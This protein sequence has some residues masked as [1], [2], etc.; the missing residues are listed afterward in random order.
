MIP[1]TLVMTLVLN[2]S[3][4]LFFNK[5]KS[6]SHSPLVLQNGTDPSGL[7]SILNSI[8]NSTTSPLSVSPPVPCPDPGQPSPPTISPAPSSNLDPTSEEL[9]GSDA[10]SLLSSGTAEVLKIYNG[11]FT[12]RKKE[13]N[14]N[15]VNRKNQTV[16]NHNTKL[17]NLRAYGQAVNHI[18]TSGNNIIN[19]G[20]KGAEE[21]L[22]K[23][24]GDLDLTG[25]FNLADLIGGEQQVDS[26]TTGSNDQTGDSSSPGEPDTNDDQGNK[27]SDSPAL[28]QL[29]KDLENVE[30]E[31][32]M[33]S[34][35]E[36]V[37][38]DQ[39][40]SA[41]LMEEGIEKQR[42]DLESKLKE[43]EDLLTT[44]ENEIQSMEAQ[45]T[46]ETNALAKI[47]L[48][49]KLMDSKNNKNNVES[50]LEKLKIDVSRLQ[51]TESLLEQQIQLASSIIQTMTTK[52]EELSKKKGELIVEIKKEQGVAPS[53]PQ[54]AS[55]IKEKIASILKNL[56]SQ[57][58]N[59]SVAGIPDISKIIQNLAE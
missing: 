33:I 13:N 53:D 59:A 58:G 26:G 49:V 41:K 1:K 43:N 5:N 38:T 17:K 45:I 30:E 57:T 18:E 9:L 36:K 52:K 11:G 56:G 39:L 21:L 40:N 44:L 34:I 50:T 4:Q 15:L 16:L 8:K 29:K 24:M 31:L 12:S 6:S 51:K 37:T 25:N 3:L 55:E 54:N 35:Q 48:Q 14:L 7:S 2:S 22:K 47:E 42:E 20:G 10:M 27:Q 19:M 28:V 23:S 46:L 32:K